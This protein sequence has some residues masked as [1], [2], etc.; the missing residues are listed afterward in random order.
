MEV[1]EVSCII[2]RLFFF[3]GI[4]LAGW[5]AGWGSE[6]RDWEVPWYFIQNERCPWCVRSMV[7]VVIAVVGRAARAAVK[8]RHYSRCGI[9][10]VSIGLVALR[11]A[12]P[13]FPW[14]VY[15]GTPPTP[16]AESPK[17]LDVPCGSTPLLDQF[18]L[19]SSNVPH[20]ER[21]ERR[22]QPSFPKRQHH[23]ETRTRERLGQEHK[24]W[25]APIDEAE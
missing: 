3:A 13:E 10:R 20:W 12:P 17:S 7:V 18:W 14:K 19:T 23:E 22:A 6:H 25:R 5:M 9:S 15:F 1:R 11:E 16:G 8:T 21:A 24:P 4:R 2:S